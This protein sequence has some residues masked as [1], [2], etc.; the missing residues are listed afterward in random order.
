MIKDESGKIYENWK[1]LVYLGKPATTHGSD[2]RCE[3]INCKNHVV[4]RGANLRRYKLPKCKYCCSKC[5]KTRK[6]VVIKTGTICVV[7]KSK[8][9]NNWKANNSEHIRRQ[10]VEWSKL[11]RDKIQSKRTRNKAKRE[12]SAS[13]FLSKMLKQKINYY[14]SL[15][16]QGTRTH[17]S[18]QKMKNLHRYK[19][20]VQILELLE[21]WKKQLGKCAITKL[22]MTT[23]YNDINSVSID[24][25]DQNC[26]YSVDNIQLVCRWVNLAK[27]IFTNDQIKQVLIDFKNIKE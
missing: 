24:R 11:N 8:A 9:L 22:Q 20:S 4:I 5:G 23:K 15:M 7:C 27:N 2:W 18:K 17:R 10:H 19:V 6:Q 21:L 3:C 16:Q 13:L 12:S 1:V 26:G 14:N 25:V